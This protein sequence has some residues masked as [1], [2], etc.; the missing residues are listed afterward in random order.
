MPTYTKGDFLKK[1]SYG[2]CYIGTSSANEKVAIK[3]GYYINIIAGFGN[4]KEL[5]VLS[6]LS[7][8]SLGPKLID[9]IYDGVI[10]ERDKNLKLES[11]TI[12]TELAMC[13]G[14]TFF[15]KRDLCTFN[16]CIKLST[17]LLI[18]IDVLHTKRITHRDIKP[19]NILI[20]NKPDGYHLKLCDFGFANFLCDLAPS[21]PCTYTAWYRAPEICWEISKYGSTAD[22][23]AVACTIYE[24]FTNDILM[25]NVTSENSKLFHGILENIPSK[26]TSEIINLYKKDGSISIPFTLKMQN[27]KRFTDIFKRLK[28]YNSTSFELWNHLDD[29]LNGMFN[30]DYRKRTQA[31]NCLE[32][33]LFNSNKL[34]INHHNTTFNKSIVLENIYF[35]NDDIIQEN[36][37][38]I[39]SKF[40]DT[41]FL[42]EIKLR[43]LFHALDLFNQFYY[44]YPSYSSEPSEVFKV[45]AGC[46]YFWNKYFSTMVFP[47]TPEFFFGIPENVNQIEYFKELDTW[48]YNFEKTVLE[49]IYC[50]EKKN[51]KYIIYRTTLYEIHDEYRSKII[52][53]NDELKKLFTYFLEVKSWNK[54]YRYM[55]RNIIKKHFNS[56]LF[57]EH[58]IE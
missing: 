35:F 39:F 40:L 3:E 7:S 24:M 45:I 19:G 51:I 32:S 23:W 26:I 2:S 49:T 30:L 11:I 48:I 17:E 46:I 9:I 52:L 29:L 47:H 42:R 58:K 5:D 25:Y 27:N 8:E 21:T 14:D 38:K 13:D 50:N 12:V 43:T 54:S 57:Q 18:A 28:N 44:K 15:K 53:T 16:V 20:F 34:I 56:N 22:I 1:G 31:N 4:I 37:I 10:N 6:R 55:Y 36:K 33:P 41:Y